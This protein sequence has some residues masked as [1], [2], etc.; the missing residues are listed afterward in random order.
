MNPTLPSL[1]E[2]ITRFELNAR[3]SL[4]QHFL[5]DP[6]ITRHIV[7]LAGDI[8]GRFVA[9]IGPGPGGLTRALLETTAQQVVAVEIDER[10]VRASQFLT[11]FY[12]EN[13]L[14]VIEADALKTDLPPLLPAPR[15]IIANLPYNIGTPLLVRWLKQADQWE[16]MVLMFQEEVALR[17][18]A[19]PNTPHYGRLAVLTQWI[20]Q[21]SI[22]MHI[23]AGAFSPPPKVRSAV[24]RIIPYKKQ[25]APNLFKAMETITAAAFGQRRKMLRRSL[26]ALNGKMLLES[27]GIEDTR[28]GETLTIAEF[29]QLA[30]HYLNSMTLRQTD[31]SR[32]SLEP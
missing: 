9:E 14:K 15:Q 21:C 2:V 30:R 4:G 11:Q 13:K 8:S 19:P 22:S 16:Q 18:C 17:I 24:V 25:P 29:E 28:R 23:A 31:S 27:A 10:A 5:L 26:A 7:S 6:N 32:H 1:R 3:K 20:A 12:P